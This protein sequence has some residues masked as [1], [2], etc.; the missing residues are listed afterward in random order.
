[1]NSQQ[2]APDRGDE[3]QGPQL[4]RRAATSAEQDRETDRKNGI[5][6]CRGCVY[7]RSA[8]GV[9]GTYTMCHY[10]YDTGELRGIRPVDCYKHDGTPYH[11][12]RYRGHGRDIQVSKRRSNDKSR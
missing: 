1:M 8:C 10:C 6:A 2:R 3:T 5:T 9:P 11:A 12:G 7:Y 4:R